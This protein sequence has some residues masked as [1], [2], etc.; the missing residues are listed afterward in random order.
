[1]ASEVSNRCDRRCHDGLYRRP[2]T[3]SPDVYFR[4]VIRYLPIDTYTTS[5]LHITD[6]CMPW[7]RTNS[8]G[9]F[10]MRQLPL[11]TFTT[12]IMINMAVFKRLDV[13]LRY[14][15]YMYGTDCI[16]MCGSGYPLF[17]PIAACKVILM[18]REVLMLSRWWMS[19]SKSSSI[20]VSSVLVGY[21]SVWFC[22]YYS[23]FT[24]HGCHKYSL[25]SPSSL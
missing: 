7:R 14:W 8:L 4:V 15:M 18:F 22:S 11:I 19:L 5:K 12:G 17:R 3:H 13:L 23:T 16:L 1:M 21:T 24:R 9:D 20:S 6:S 10:H 25:S 2:T